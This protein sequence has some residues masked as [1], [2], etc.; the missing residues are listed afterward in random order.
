MSERLKKFLLIAFFLFST[1][2]IGTMLYFLFF[3]PP[4]S[5]KTTEGEIEQ[6]YDGSFPLSE[7]G[8]PRQGASEPSATQ[9]LPEASEIAEGGLT[10]TQTL[11]ASSV[12]ASSSS[13]DGNGMNYYDPADGRFY[14]V[15]A[16]GTVTSLSDRS[17]PA[18][19]S[20]AWNKEKAKAV[21]EFPDGSNVVY[22]FETEHQVTLPSHWQAFSFSPVSDDLFAKNMGV[23]PGNRSLIVSNPDGS[24]VKS[25]QDLGENAGR[26][27]IRPSPN[28]QIVAFSDTGDVQSGLGRKMILP[29]GMNHEN[30]KGLI[31]EGVDF[32]S[33]WNPSGSLLLYSV[34]GETSDYRPQLWTVNGTPNRLGEE[35]R[36]LNVFT[37]ADKCT[38][39]GPTTVYCAVPQALP[40]GSGIQPAVA[41]SLPDDVY[42][43]DLTS[44]RLSLVARPADGASIMGLVLSQDGTS[45]FFT[46]ALTGR[47]ER[48]KLKEGI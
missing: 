14:A 19:Q 29:I 8:N 38:F 33:V 9:Q 32:R 4:P 2:G 3:A 43:I 21:L 25:I 16:D 15:K 17:F 23:D 24:Q 27:F 12:Q 28:R 26:V 48:L 11:T 31:V 46:N 34:A 44:G 36:S 20:V 10:K 40:S 35:R 42:K 18:V 39:A 37:W 1:I 45:L 13:A 22:D 41:A 6:E 7:T 30:L 47:L 5:L